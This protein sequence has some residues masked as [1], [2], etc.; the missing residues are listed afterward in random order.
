MNDLKNVYKKYESREEGLTNSEVIERLKIYGT[1]ELIE[2]KKDSPLKIFLMQFMDLLILLLIVAAT[3]AY[4]IGDIID[5]TVILI[6]VLLNGTIGFIQEYRSEKAMEKLKSLVTTEA[7]VKR[8]GQIQKIVGTQITIG[9]LVFIEEGDKI[10]ADLIIIDASDLKIDES[11]LTGESFPVTKD[12]KDIDLLN[13]DKD[14]HDDNMRKAIAYM[15]SNIISGRG[16]GIVIA[17]GMNTSIGKI[18]QMINEKKDETT[19]LQKKIRSLSKTL[20]LIAIVVCVIVFILQFLKGSSIVE[21]FMT[22]VSLAVAAIPEGLPATLTLTLALSMQRMA[23]SNAIVKKLLSIETLGSCTVVCTDKT[24]TLTLNKMKVRE[25]KITN[26][27][28]SY[29]IATLCNNAIIKDG[30]SI[31]D[32]TDVAVLN[33]G[34][35]NG[36]K[37]LELEKIYPRIKE[38]SLDSVRKRMT[39]IHKTGE[40]LYIVSKGAPEIILERSKYVDND[41]T[42]KALSNEDRSRIIKNI[43]EMTDDALRVLSLAYREVDSN[44]N[45]D[46]PDLVESDLIFVGL[47]GIMDLPRKE[48]KNAV[49]SCKTAKIKVVMITG[50]HKSTA[51]SIAREIG[52]LNKGK[53]LTGHDLD[54]L[55]QEEFNSIVEDVEVYARVFPE[56]K[57]R[58]VEAL[59]KHDNIVSMTGDGVNDAPALKKA[60]IGVGMGSGTDVSKESADMIIQDDNFATIVEAIKEGRKIFDNIKRFVKFQVSTN[61]GAILTIVLSS[62]LNLP[63]PFNPI[64]ILWINIMMDGPP[65]QSLGMEGAERNIMN[66]KPAKGDILSKNNLI[67]VVIAGVVMTIGTLLLFVYE[68]NSQKDEKVAITMAFTIFVIYQ[69]FNAINN[70]ADSNE[71]NNFFWTAILLSFSLQLL[72]IYIPF[73]QEIFKTAG[74]EIFDWILILIVSST[75]LIS[76]KVCSH[77][78]K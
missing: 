3:A 31:G 39:T 28:R 17:T 73:L 5:S 19:P 64:Q 15:D 48:A 76:E 55:S 32:P 36:Y 7:I 14:S 71:K 47:L 26:P 65:A 56:Q 9:D 10:P 77:I 66:R 57:V 8:D 63:I 18:A 25:T 72:I 61:I 6:V 43:E 74:I 49:T 42:I 69:I 78:L 58:I 21:T 41:G 37:K 59:Q 51:S 20:S 11:S 27:N 13:V 60:S 67:K 53:V 62:I 2:D 22:A 50:D 54:E 29:E 4:F 34:L 35:N 44:F 24:G 40:K 16:T 46:D 38:H 30:K 70:R 33:Y 45:V 75:I 68:L 52:I 12:I 23:K 1:N